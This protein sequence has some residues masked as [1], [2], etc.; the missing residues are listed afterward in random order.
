MIGTRNNNG[1]YGVTANYA[2]GAGFEV[3]ASGTQAISIGR[4]SSANVADA[5]SV[6]AFSTSSGANAIAIG[7]TACTGTGSNGI[8]IGNSAGD[9]NNT[10]ANNV[11]IGTDTMSASATFTGDIVMGSNVLTLV[12]AATGT[13]LLGMRLQ[14]NLVPGGTQIIA[15]LTGT[16]GGIG[17]TYSITS[18]PLSTTTAMIAYSIAAN[19]IGMGDNSLNRV[20]GANNV[21]IGYQSGTTLEL[22]DG[23]TLL[24]ASTSV[25]ALLSNTVVI[26]NT[27]SATANDAVAIGNGVTANQVGGLFVRHRG[28]LAITVNPAGFVAGTN[29]LVEITS[30]R[31][32][33]QNIR[34]LEDVSEKIDA[35][36]PVRYQ[37]KPGFGDD[38]EHIGFIA[39][40]V[41]A[42]FPEFVTY[43]ADGNVTG[44]MFD[45]VTSVLLKE[46]QSLRARLAA[47]GL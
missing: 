28:P 42:I 21:A 1:L 30:S 38:R 10:G 43:D 6:G 20:L 23:N 44:M 27:A 14:G 47:A 17:S 26:G 32:F 40:E 39:E 8:I 7:N 35:L 34:D 36:R 37:A 46:I 3:R 16:L 12:T 45:R 33:K 5:I 25:T 41:Q 29:E 4:N 2:I 31:R 15:L 18:S 19:N 11:M 22:G 13:F 9:V 24:G